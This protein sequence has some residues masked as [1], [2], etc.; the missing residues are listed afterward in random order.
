MRSTCFPVV[1]VV[2]SNKDQVI[3][4]IENLPVFI[5]QNDR[6][7]EG[8]STSIKAGIR[9]LVNAYPPVESAIVS[10]V[11]QPFLPLDQYYGYRWRVTQ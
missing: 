7:K 3:A 11:D 5:V 4:E 9:A 10:V 2:G 6:W 1:V 8:M